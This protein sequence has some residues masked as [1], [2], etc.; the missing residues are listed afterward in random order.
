MA[1]LTAGPIAS[2]AS[3]VLLTLV[4]VGW[5]GIGLRLI[6]FSGLDKVLT[7]SERLLFSLAVGCIVM[8]LALLVVGL[9]GQLNVIVLWGVVGVSALSS[10]SLLRQS[11]AGLHPRGP[12]WFWM[13]VA[14]ACGLSVIQALAPP[15]GTDA[16]SYHLGHPRLFIEA[17][18]IAWIPGS[19]ESLWPYLTEMFFM[20]G[21][22]LQG[23][24]AAS[25][26]HWVFYPLTAWAIYLFSLRHASLGRARLAALSFIFTP[27]AFAQSGHAYID[28]SLAFFTFLAAYA[29]MVVPESQRLGSAYMAGFICGGALAVKYLGIGV[30]ASLFILF[31]CLHEKKRAWVLYV[32]GALTASG[33]WYIRS[34]FELGNPVFPFMSKLFG[35]G[36]ESELGKY[37]GMGKDVGSLIMLGWNITLHPTA[38]GGEILGPLFL[39]FAPLALCELHKHRRRELGLT[40]FVATYTFFIF[41]QSQQVRFFLSVV[42]FY[43]LAVAAGYD[44]AEKQAATLRILARGVLICILMFHMG[45]Y[46]YRTRDAWPVVLG[47]QDATKYLLKH[48]RS[49]EGYRWLAL[50]MK[51]G[52]R[53]FNSAEH[54]FFYG[55]LSGMQ[56]NN[57]LFRQALE[58]VH[59]SLVGHLHNESYDYL[60][61]LEGHNEELF[62]FAEQNGYRVAHAYSRN[63]GD[64]EFRYVIYKK[65]R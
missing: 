40:I 37:V 9:F 34:W 35:S 18:R 64:M 62:D 15:I 45:I 50:N 7:A 61:L 25:L 2:I 26:F 38:F 54:K 3:L 44:W 28:L 17:G 29:V 52:Q 11:L 39:A 47:H 5:M 43:C 36:Y 12:A 6:R 58:S 10:A 46:V 4:L 60:W 13:P 16:L 32:A 65:D 51:P 24:A 31:A 55:E 14:A 8:S 1:Y 30:F 27:V 57:R 41:T 49:F 42:P 20:L 63:E 53:V 56:I 22:A 33:V 21:L 19:R 59:K 23:T 48:E